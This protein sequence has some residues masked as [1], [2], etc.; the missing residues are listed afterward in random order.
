MAGDSSDAKGRTP[1]ADRPQQ[2]HSLASFWAAARSASDADQLAP[3]GEAQQTGVQARL[4]QAAPA[5][6]ADREPVAA[7]R[8]ASEAVTRAGPRGAGDAHFCPSQ[9]G[10]AGPRA[11]VED[12]L[13]GPERL[14]STAAEEAGLEQEAAGRGRSAADPGL[15]PRARAGS[16]DSGDELRNPASPGCV[17]SGLRLELSPGANEQWPEEDDAS[18]SPMQQECDMLDADTRQTQP[19]FAGLPGPAASQGGAG[20]GLAGGS[21]SGQSAAAAAL[22]ALPP[23]S[24]VDTSVLDA[25]P[26]Q[27]KRE[28]ERA[29]GEHPLQAIKLDL[30]WKDT[31]LSSSILTFATLLA[32]Q[33]GDHPCCS[34]LR[35]PV[36]DLH[37]AGIGT[38]R[39][40]PNRGKRKRGGNGRH[41][42][43]AAR[44]LKRHLM[45]SHFLAAKPKCAS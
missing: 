23:A 17:Y 29:Y 6:L 8:L 12:T 28:I 40:P 19:G 26:L 5:S 44:P 43:A 3:S 37:C 32:E 36:S 38:L 25:L 42:S 35:E 45:D 41:P 18:S 30:V 1:Q 21:R 22:Q 27:M 10:L 24:Q 13:A 33:C 15:D 2:P 39:S 16:E 7:G 11:T 34:Y 14:G 9:E 4:L 31:A 20:E